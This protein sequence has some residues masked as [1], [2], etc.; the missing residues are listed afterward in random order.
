MLFR[1]QNLVL[2]S[3]VEGRNSNYQERKCENEGTTS[4]DIGHNGW[5]CFTF[6]YPEQH[7]M[8]FA[9]IWFRYQ[10]IRGVNTFSFP[11]QL[12]NINN[13]WVPNRMRLNTSTLIYL[14][15]MEVY[16]H[17]NKAETP[18]R[19]W[20]IYDKLLTE[21]V[22]SSVGC[23]PFYADISDHL[24]NCTKKEEIKEI[25]DSLEEKSNFDSPCIE[26][27]KYRADTYTMQSNVE[28]ENVYYP[29][30]GSQLNVTDGWFRITIHFPDLTYK[31]IEQ[32]RSY[33]LQALI[34][35]AGGY[36]G[37]FIGCTISDLPALLFFMYKKVSKAC[38]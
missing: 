21:K 31:N 33:T 28:F 17:R 14:L 30:K 20:D 25:H 36:I 22:Y 19:D 34:G 4:I 24:Q 9:S 16:R 12:M 38:F 27:K 37:L 15:D 5:K 11:Q 29:G 6:H 18:C 10:I 32:T 7:S 26:L 3:C 13:R 1:L 35:N 8:K 2:N 23:R